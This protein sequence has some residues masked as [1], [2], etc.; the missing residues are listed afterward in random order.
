MDIINKKVFVFLLGL[1]ALSFGIIFLWPLSFLSVLHD[2]SGFTV[3]TTDIRFENT[4]QYELDVESDEYKQIRQILNTFSY[5]RT[6][7]TFFGDGT[8]GGSDAGW[9]TIYNGDN[10]FVFSGSGLIIINANVY[11]MGFFSN[12]SER[13]L[14]NEIR[15]VLSN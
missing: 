7:K 8:T 11:R 14:M 6:F 12:K 3:I 1:L 2:D 5:R 15:S 10:I 9:L 13:A 4:R